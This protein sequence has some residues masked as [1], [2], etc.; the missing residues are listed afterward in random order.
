M[1]VG[2]L[3]FILCDVWSRIDDDSLMRVFD[4]FSY[5][6]IISF[7]REGRELAPFSQQDVILVGNDHLFAGVFND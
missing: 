1:P 2:S 4:L 7:D 6:Q 3:H 5:H